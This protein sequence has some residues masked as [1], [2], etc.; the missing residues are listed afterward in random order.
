[1]CIRDSPQFHQ[2]L[3]NKLKLVASRR[4]GFDRSAGGLALRM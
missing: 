3:R 1:M 4:Q 2:V